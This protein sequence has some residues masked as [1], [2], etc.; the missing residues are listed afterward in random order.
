MKKICVLVALMLFCT[1]FACAEMDEQILI[2]DNFAY[3]ILE[4]GSAKITSYAYYEAE[5]DGIE[6]LTIPDQLD[7]RKVSTIGAGAFSTMMNC[8]LLLYRTA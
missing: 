1:T 5:D 4:D 7:G 3:T 6:N 8:M 2:C